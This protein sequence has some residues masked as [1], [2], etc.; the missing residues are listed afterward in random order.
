MLTHTAYGYSC[1]L[2]LLEQNFRDGAGGSGSAV[3]SYSRLTQLLK[4]N[5]R[6]RLCCVLGLL[7]PKPV[8]I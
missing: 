4:I 7:F 5:L 3:D 8:L 1:C 6:Q 2:D